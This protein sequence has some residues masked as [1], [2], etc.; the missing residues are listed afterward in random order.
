VVAAAL[1]V[2]IGQK[3]YMDNAN[4]T[5]DKEYATLSANTD[6]DKMLTIQNQLSAVSS[7]SDSKRMNSRIFDML[8]V[9]IP[10]DSQITISSF[11][12]QPPEGEDGT[13][14]SLV[15][16]EGQ[17][18]GGYGGLE[19]FEKTIASTVLEFKPREGSSATGDLDCGNPTLQCR[20]LAVGDGDRSQAIA[21]SE[22]NFGRD[23]TDTLTLRF[24]LSFTV[25]PEFLLNSV[26]NVS[27]KVGRDGN[28]TDSALGVPET[29]FK[30]R[31]NNGD[32]SAGGGDE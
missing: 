7:L 23:E 26:D 8:G 10:Q 16:I 30:D 5:I 4:G 6:L 32:A 15:T 14:G 2:F 3:L 11:L 24:K 12:V 1:F 9:I 17:S 19:V 13:N 29:I 25:V 22:M 28:V 21:V 20:Y 18:A 31:V 27:L